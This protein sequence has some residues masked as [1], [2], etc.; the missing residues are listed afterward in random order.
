LEKLSEQQAREMEL[1]QDQLESI[2]EKADLYVRTVAED[3]PYTVA[4]S[5]LAST[6][7]GAGRTGSVHVTEEEIEME[8]IRIREGGD[9]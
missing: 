1:Q 3:S 5:I 7:S 2:M 8:W 9:S 6:E 4:E